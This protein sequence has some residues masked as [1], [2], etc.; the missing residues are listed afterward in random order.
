MKNIEKKWIIS[1]RSMSFEEPTK[2]DMCEINT[3]SFWIEELAMPICNDCYHDINNE[4][5]KESK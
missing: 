1:V 2:C 5:R 3:S 4:Q